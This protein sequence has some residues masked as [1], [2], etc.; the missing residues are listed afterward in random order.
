MMHP[1]DIYIYNDL[2]LYPNK[3]IYQLITNLI[4]ITKDNKK[5]FVTVVILPV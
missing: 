4:T 2:Q 1:L 5:V 3:S